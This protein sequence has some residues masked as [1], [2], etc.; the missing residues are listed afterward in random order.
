V[1]ETAKVVFPTW[2]DGTIALF[3]NWGTITY[4]VLVVP[5]CWAIESNLRN[6][7]LVSVTLMVIGAGIR[8]VPLQLDPNNK[9][10]LYIETYF[11]HKMILFDKQVNQN[12]VF[13]T[14][15]AHLCAIFNGIAGIVTM[16]A[17]PA[18]SAVWFPVHVNQ[19][20]VSYKLVNTIN[21][22]DFLFRKEQQLLELDKLRAYFLCQLHT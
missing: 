7:M 3:T 1:A 2:S 8:C 17:P 4:L 15:A 19:L 5:M 20:L 10:K 22:A 13:P 9:V 6:T 16:A 12:D 21:Q 18:I 14:V 11:D